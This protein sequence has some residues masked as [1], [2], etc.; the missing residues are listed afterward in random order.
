MVSTDHD[1]DQLVELLH[2]AIWKQLPDDKYR[3]EVL[4]TDEIDY[5]EA[6][7]ESH[8]LET[9]GTG[10]GLLD[11]FKK[12]DWKYV[13]LSDDNVKF[14]LVDYVGIGNARLEMIADSA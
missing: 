8:I 1:E 13:S 5:I 3:R 4:T 2:D 14:R 9:L 7:G 12:G 11:Q 6:N 10:T